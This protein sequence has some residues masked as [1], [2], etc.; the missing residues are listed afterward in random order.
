MLTHTVAQT[1]ASMRICAHAHNFKIPLTALHLAHICELLSRYPV[2]NRNSHSADS[3]SAELLR[4]QHRLGENKQTNRQT[5][6]QTLLT[7]DKK[8]KA[9]HRKDQWEQEKRKEEGYTLVTTRN[10]AILFIGERCPQI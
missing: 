5:N 1:A 7:W 3:R 10:A 8:A 2:F 4:R 9:S 6:K